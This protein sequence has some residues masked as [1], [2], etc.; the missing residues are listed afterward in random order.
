VGRPRKHP[1]TEK[2]V[3][4][5]EESALITK[6]VCG[7]AQSREASY[8]RGEQVKKKG[9]ETITTN[10]ET[11]GVEIGSRCTEREKKGRLRENVHRKG[12]GK[13]TRPRRWGDKSHLSHQWGKSGRLI[14]HKAGKNTEG[15]SPLRDK[16]HRL[17]KSDRGTGPPRSS[18]HDKTP[19]PGTESI[20]LK[21]K[22]RSDVSRG[23]KSFES[24][25]GTGYDTGGEQPGQRRARKGS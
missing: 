24:S 15:K 11:G 7:G 13:K 25:A 1:Q 23:K 16:N 12:T 14:L 21:T 6:G 8:P 22:R 9:C 3:R 5:K 2:T 4:K 18:H 17:G 19:S 10:H 20:T